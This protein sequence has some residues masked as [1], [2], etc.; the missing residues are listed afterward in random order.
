MDSERGVWLPPLPFEGGTPTSRVGGEEL[1]TFAASSA[2]IRASTSSI[3]ISTFS[4]LR[5]KWRLTEIPGVEHC[6]VKLTGVNNTTTPVHIIEAQQNLLGNLLADVHGHTLVL[7]PLDQSEEVF[8]EHFEHHA[9]VGAVRS[10]VSE[11]VK[12]GNYM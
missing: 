3:A 5:S 10:L 6:E 1:A 8:P 11:V 12:E 2:S 7:M 4:G 9:N